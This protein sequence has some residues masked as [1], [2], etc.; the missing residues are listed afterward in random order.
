MY[1]VNSYLSVGVD[2]KICALEFLDLKLQKR[3]E[4]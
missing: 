1:Q 3:Y 2:K 4:N